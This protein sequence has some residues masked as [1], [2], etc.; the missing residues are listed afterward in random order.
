VILLKEFFVP[1]PSQANET[2]ETVEQEIETIKEQFGEYFKNLIIPENSQEIS[3][4]FCVQ[5]TSAYFSPHS[6]SA[7]VAFRFASLTFKLNFPVYLPIIH[8]SP[9]P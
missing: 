2:K 5:C 8:P 4:K 3:H 6:I 7:T 1:S 9:P